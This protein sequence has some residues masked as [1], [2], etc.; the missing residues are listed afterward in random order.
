ML[1]VQIS[2]DHATSYTTYSCP[3]TSKPFLRTFKKIVFS[4]EIPITKCL[5]FFVQNDR[6]FYQMI[7]L[8]TLSRCPN[9][10]L[11]KNVITY[12]QMC[13]WILFLCFLASVYVPKRTM[14][15][16]NGRS[17]SIFDCLQN[18]IRQT[19]LCQYLGGGELLRNVF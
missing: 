17:H 5:P 15:Y 3:F 19:S 4:M 9:E 16:K 8:H 13:Y 14:P 12:C 11:I 7:L 6:N 2:P 18:A 1:K 10:S